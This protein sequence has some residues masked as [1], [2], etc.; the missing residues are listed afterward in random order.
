VVR[1]R[2]AC[3]GLAVGVNVLRND[4]AAALAVAAVAGARFIRVNVHIGARVTDQ[5]LIEGEAG[6]TLRA[7]R[8]LASDVAIWADVDVKHS[9]PLGDRPITDEAAD[10]VLRGMASAVLVTGHG[11]GQPVDAHKLADVRRA[12]TVPVYVASGATVE[13]LP[14]LAR[15]CDGVIVGT[16]LCHG[17]RAGNR[18]DPM[19]AAAFARAFREAYSTA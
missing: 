17:G 9:A 4:A 12:V 8:A 5:G 15:A 11:T 16:A 19:R 14:A 6:S 2:D 13:S 18:V 10:A 3:P 7:R 1:V